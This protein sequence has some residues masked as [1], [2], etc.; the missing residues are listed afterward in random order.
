MPTLKDAVIEMPM[1]GICQIDKYK[2][3]KYFDRF[4]F[5]SKYLDHED[6]SKAEYKL[7][8][9]KNQSKRFNSLKIQISEGDAL[10]IIDELK[11]NEEKNPIFILGSSFKRDD[12]DPS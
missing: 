10:F 7:C 6:K 11:L 3:I 12:Y 1:T 2:A 4:C 5:I 9:F 8:R